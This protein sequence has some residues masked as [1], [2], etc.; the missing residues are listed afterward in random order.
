MKQHTFLICI[1][2]YTGIF[3]FIDMAN[4]ST[5]L[6]AHGHVIRFNYNTVKDGMKRK[7]RKH[8]GG[9]ARFVIEIIFIG[10][11]RRGCTR[12]STAINACSISEQIR[13]RAPPR[14][15][16]WGGAGFKTGSAQL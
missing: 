9:I 12:Y 15:P 13:S 10:T 4:R 8:R 5:V 7:K 1:T 3:T 11:Q 6:I 2:N 16:L 14:V